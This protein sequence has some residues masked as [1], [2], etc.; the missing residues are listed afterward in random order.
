MSLHQQ[1]ERDRALRDA[2]WGVVSDDV[3]WLQADLDHRSV[4]GRVMDRAGQTAKGFASQSLDAARRNK[5]AFGAAGAA[6]VLWLAR[7]P[8]SHAAQRLW[9]HLRTPKPD[10]EMLGNSGEYDQ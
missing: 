10:A 8:L 1:L 5:L 4:S 9:A 7:R 2:A 3:T 6:L